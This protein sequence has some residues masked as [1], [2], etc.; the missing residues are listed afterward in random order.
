MTIRKVIEIITGQCGWQ[1]D[2][3]LTNLKKKRRVFKHPHKL[4]RITI[5]G[6]LDKIS[7]PQETG[8]ILRGACE[9][10]PQS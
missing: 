5:T 6:D 9:N 2:E 4:R 8:G 3:K 10:W 1:L 7:P